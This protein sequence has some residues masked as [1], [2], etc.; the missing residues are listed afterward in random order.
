MLVVGNLARRNLWWIAWVCLGLIVFFSGERKALIVFGI[1]SAALIA[2]GRLLS[3]LYVIAGAFAVLVLL[4]DLVDDPYLSRQIRTVTDPV[5]TGD[6]T[7]AIATGEA[8]TGDTRSNAQRG[9]AIALARELISQNLVF[10]VGT[11]AYEQIVET[12][13]AYLPSFLRSGIHG[14]FLRV[15]T[16]NGLIGLVAYLAIW[17]VTSLRTRTVLRRAVQQRLLTASQA[18]LLQIVIFVPCLLYISF[19]ASGTHSLIVLALVS[20]L[21]DGI[22]A[23]L[24]PAPL[25]RPLPAMRTAPPLSAPRLPAARLR[26]TLGTTP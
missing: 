13:F 17:L 3:S 4:S 25:R 10:G 6:F 5:E 22:H 1:L 11:N 16:E 8:A 14:E 24:K 15:L 7:T 19:E 26:R 20:L 9:F 23:W 12:R 21:P 2:R 18:S